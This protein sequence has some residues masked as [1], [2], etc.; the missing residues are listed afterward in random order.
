MKLFLGFGRVFCFLLV[1]FPFSNSFE[2]SLALKLFLAFDE[3]CFFDGTDGIVTVL[4]RV[5]I[6]CT[7]AGLIGFFS[8]PER[9]CAFINVF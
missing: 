5:Q 8:V 2:T 6:W 1:V 7:V 4:P 3:M 9:N